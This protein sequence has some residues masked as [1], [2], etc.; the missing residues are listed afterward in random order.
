MTL[1]KRGELSAN[2]SRVLKAGW[3]KGQLNKET[4]SFSDLVHF[5]VNSFTIH[6]GR[7]KDS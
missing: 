6:D 1:R 4:N 3:Q 2:K 7:Q 5:V